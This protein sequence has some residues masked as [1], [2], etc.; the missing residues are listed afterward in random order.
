MV[1][2]HDHVMHGQLYTNLTA[3]EELVSD[4]AIAPSRLL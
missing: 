2:D 3:D 4:L 1:N